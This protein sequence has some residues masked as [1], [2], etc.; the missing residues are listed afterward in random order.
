MSQ[1]LQVSLVLMALLVQL[2]HL[3]T[4]AQRVDRGSPE[5]TVPLELQVSLRVTIQWSPC[6]T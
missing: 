3:A 2:D 6:C 1:A 5:G 4:E